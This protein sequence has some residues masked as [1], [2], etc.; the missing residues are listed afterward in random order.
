M[1]VD[2]TKNDMVFLDAMIPSS[3]LKR[4]F[5]INV[6]HNR[7][8][9]HSTSINRISILWNYLGSLCQFVEDQEA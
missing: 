8:P 6:K 2:P 4:L 1:T 7:L 5:T 3:G 9:A